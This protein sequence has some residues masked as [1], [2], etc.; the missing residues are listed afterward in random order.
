MPVTLCVL[1]WAHPGKAQ[2]LIDYE[3][4]VLEILAD[5]GGQVVQRARTRSGSADE[6]VEIQFLTFSS[7]SVLETFMS[8]PRRRSMAPDREAAIARTDLYRV[9]LDRSVH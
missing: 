1:L 3:D 4:R 7:D 2:A 8:D 6:P 5:H 9:E